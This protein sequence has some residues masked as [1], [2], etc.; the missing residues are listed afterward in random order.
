MGNKEWEEWENLNGDWEVGIVGKGQWS[1]QL[2]LG[3]WE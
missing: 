2:E 3:S 1:W